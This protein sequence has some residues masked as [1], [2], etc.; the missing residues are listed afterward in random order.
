M[1]QIIQSNL[2]FKFS[3]EAP[4]TK[5]FLKWFLIY[6]NEIFYEMRWSHNHKNPQKCLNKHWQKNKISIKKEKKNTCRKFRRVQ[7]S[8]V[9]NARCATI[10]KISSKIH[11]E[12]S[13]EDR[14]F[15][16]RLK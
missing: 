3:T 15:L 4:I 12:T 6:L 16:S 1:P 2:K 9:K 14:H 5:I 7:N 11:E 8:I 10:K 13:E